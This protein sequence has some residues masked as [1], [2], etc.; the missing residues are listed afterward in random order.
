MRIASKLS[1]VVC[2]TAGFA[3]SVAS[4]VEARPGQKGSA[5]V[6]TSDAAA[7]VD[8]TRGMIV[9]EGVAAA[10]LRAPSPRVARVKAAR[11]AR[12]S[13][14][15]GLL[16]R[17]R[18]L[19]LGERTVGAAADADESGAE[20]LQKS[21][22][23]A[24]QLSVSYASD[25]S[26]VLT[27][28]LPL[29]SVRTAVAGPSTHRRPVADEADSGPAIT[30]VVLD[31]RAAGIAPALGLSVSGPA[32]A[33][34]G[35]TVFHRSEKSALADA[36]AGAHILTAGA[37]AGTD[38]TLALKD[39]PRAERHDLRSGQTADGRGATTPATAAQVHRAL[40]AGALLIV[41]L[42]SRP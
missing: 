12:A 5:I 35:P 7:S 25:G 33:H 9:A 22:E 21:V 16:R 28:G 30:T 8:W 26:V 40:A 38:A 6:D 41:V 27:L 3:G 1:L 37:R 24:Q 31:A 11:Q 36:R 20:R 14:R 23:R 29:E 19:A 10:D 32:G 42:G 18:A 4:S 2:V 39:E 13:A 17:A 15:K 34:A